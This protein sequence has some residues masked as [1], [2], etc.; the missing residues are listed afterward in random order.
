MQVKICGLTNLKDAITAA[1]AGADMLGFNFYPRSA[2]FIEPEACATIVAAL[3]ALGYVGLRTVGVFVNAS[4]AEVTTQAGRCGL[5]LIQLH[6]DEPPEM[7]AQVRRQ[8]AAGV[9]AFKAIRPASASEA[10]EALA[11]YAA[12]ADAPALLADAY[13][14]GHYGGTGETGDWGLAAALSRQAPVL[15]AGG[16][17]PDNV[18]AA[19]RQVRPWGVDV[20]SGVESAP[21]HK[22]A[23]RLTA[24]VTAAHA[25][26]AD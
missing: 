16:L 9:R 24:F 15:L 5:D 3:H 14:P 18:A 19:I 20:A 4:L 6:G 26:V 2:R 21:G 1:E 13:R 7:L 10:Q 23:R 17:T 11:R 25:A 22:D 8:T 12:G